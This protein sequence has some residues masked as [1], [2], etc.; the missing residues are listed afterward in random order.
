MDG[1]PLYE[2]AREGKALPKPIESRPVTI[3]H[4]ALADFRAS[5]Q[6]DAANGHSFIFPQ[7]KLSVEAQSERLKVLKLVNEDGKS[8][9]FAAS[10]FVEVVVREKMRRALCSTGISSRDMMVVLS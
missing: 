6:H 3:S 2:Y 1:K 7:K 5:A 4:L 8:K 10:E 9:D